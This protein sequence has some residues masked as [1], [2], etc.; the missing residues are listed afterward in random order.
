MSRPLTLLFLALYAI[1]VLWFS[2]SFD[3]KTRTLEG[4]YLADRKFGHWP[5]ALTLV[6]SWF[7]GTS[8]IGSLQAFYTDGVSA[9][10]KLIFPSI[11]CWLV[12]ILLF[13]RR[14]ANQP[15]LSMPE[16]IE[17]TYGPTART[18]L[19]LVI[20]CSVTAL[21]GSQLVAAHQVL[22]GLFQ[23]PHGAP[24]SP[25]LTMGFTAAIVTI[26]TTLGGFR[27]VVM[28]DIL[29]V[30]FIAIG[31]LVMAVPAVIM[32]SGV[33]WP[34]FWHHVGLVRSDGF[35]NFLPDA[36]KQLA[37][38][39]TFVMAWSIAPELWQ[40]MTAL[41]AN[42]SIAKNDHAHVLLKKR[43]MTATALALGILCL[44]YMLVVFVGLASPALIGSEAGRQPASVMIGLTNWLHQDWAI[45]LVLVGF[46]A[47][48]GSTMDSTLNVGSLTLTHDVMER[49]W[50]R[51]FA[52]KLSASALMRLCKMATLV[53]PLPALVMAAWHQNIISV[54]WISAD[55]YACAMFVPVVA[56]L[57]ASKR[58]Q[59]SAKA[60]LWAMLTGS[61]W[62]LITSLIH[63]GVVAEIPWP[64]APYSTLWGVFLSSLA[65]AVG[66]F[67]PAVT[68]SLAH[69][70]QTVLSAESPD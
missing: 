8:T 38:M 32:I 60:G 6:A 64:E 10:W 11:G 43:A 13:S 26:Y 28:T 4:F 48:I 44:F 29:Q 23:T 7:G 49:F 70:A 41:H 37:M 17:N 59:P 19:A 62:V 21:M 33:S 27:A 42:A 31:L 67:M 34:L 51:C 16:A 18:I 14:M 57:Y 9:F 20:A 47:A 50:R 24:L 3:R 68:A 1:S 40:R 5:I 35:W 30:G 12:I 2:K 61:A 63:M 25:W 66:Q 15:G 56:M 45:A 55:I 53:M 52:H 69:S 46:I 54:L 58:F 22:S 39:L 36:G 65:F